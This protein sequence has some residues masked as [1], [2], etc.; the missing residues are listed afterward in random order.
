MFVCNCYPSQLCFSARE[1]VCGSL[2]ACMLYSDSFP[3]FLRCNSSFETV[4]R[5]KGRCCFE[6][7][8]S[9]LFPTFLYLLFVCAIHLLH[10]V[11]LFLLSAQFRSR[12]CFDF[13]W[14][15]LT[16]RFTMHENNTFSCSTRYKTK[17]H[18]LKYL[19]ARNVF[20]HEKKCELG[21]LAIFL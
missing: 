2:C 15:W 13:L 7:I 6:M 5:K 20:M 14:W 18:W 8:F 19:K 3:L 11:A 21:F 1:W 16:V 10:F 17:S 12:F 4:T 9:F